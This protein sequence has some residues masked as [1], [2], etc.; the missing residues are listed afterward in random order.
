MK[1]QEAI[2]TMTEVAGFTFITK[3][4][5]EYS[6]QM[7]YYFRSPKGDLHS[8]SLGGLRKRAEREQWLAW[9][10]ARQAKLKRGIQLELF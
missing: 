6:N 8:W 10:R 4:R 3:T 2:Q 7:D 1:L 5:C 9:S